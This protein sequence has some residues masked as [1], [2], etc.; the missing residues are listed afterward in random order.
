[1]R[2]KIHLKADRGQSKYATYIKLNPLLRR[3]NI[4]DSIV[5]TY[6]L[7]HTTRI[8]MISH[9]LQIELGRQRRPTIPPEERLCICGDIETENHYTQH[10]NL[11]T[12]IR[13]KY[14][15]N[16][17]ME[18]HYILDSNFTHDYITELHNC[19]EI[20]IRRSW[21]KDGPLIM[22]MVLW[23]LLFLVNFH[24]IFIC[25]YSIRSIITLLLLLCRHR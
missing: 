6:K 9:N 12:H 25:I 14:E 7:H 16:D 19:R 1:M 15:I 8:R 24:E 22:N 3:P 13:H 17:E 21:N 4:Y 18:L 23:H 5:P 11:Y 2:E 10:C 20:F